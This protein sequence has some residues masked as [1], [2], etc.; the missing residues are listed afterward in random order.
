MV[1]GY[2]HELSPMD[3]HAWFEAY[4]GGRWYTFDAT[5]AVPKGG[6]VTLGYGHDAA[7][8]AIFNQFGP[9]LET[10]EMKVTVESMDGA[11]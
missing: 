3:L 11:A 9:A 2:L 5:Q 7:Q 10:H 4:V 8:V 6:R 1:V